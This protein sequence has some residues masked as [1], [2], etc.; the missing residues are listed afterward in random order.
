MNPE[1]SAP[2]PAR[3]TTSYS[4]EGKEE[5]RPA[6][7]AEFELSLLRR[8]RGISGQFKDSA[9]PL[10]V[11]RTAL[12]SGMELLAASEGCVAVLPPDDER[13]QII[14]AVPRESIWDDC[15]L[16]AFIRG[17][18]IQMP[19][20]LALGRLRRRGRMWG[21]L[22]VRS[23][24]AEFGWNAREAIS[25]IAATTS[26]LMEGMD[27][28]RIRDVRARLDFKLI[29]QLRPK[30]L[31]YQVL[32][33]LRTLTDYDHSASLLI[34]DANARHLEVAA[35]QIAWKKTKSQKIGL[36]ITIDDELRHMLC[37]NV[38]LGFDRD[39]NG[40]RPWG[41][42]RGLALAKLLDYN[43]AESGSTS[44]REASVLY[45]PL[46]SRNTLLGLLKIA[47]TRR[48]ILG[49][50]EAN[51]VSHFLPQVTVALQISQRTE[52]LEQQII[53]AHR[54]H[55]MADLARGVSHD[56]NNAL[57]AILPLVQQMQA[58]LGDGRIEPSVFA[59][60]LRAVEESVQVC[61][62]IV[63]GMLSFARGASRNTGQAYVRQSVE[64]ARTILKDG[65]TRRAVDVF[66]D[67]EPDLAPVHGV[68]AD[69]DQLLLNLLSN[70]RDAMPRGGRLSVRAKQRE[71]SVELVVEDTGCGIPPEHMEK[72]KEPFF[73]TKPDGNGLGLAI[74]RSIVWQMRGK[75]DIRSVPGE[76]TRVTV[77]FPLYQPGL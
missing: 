51:L 19:P 6:M 5:A 25:A 15:L 16:S 75:L 63:G 52:S 34:Y 20:N 1:G 61:R 54:K 74:C 39:S 49:P 12:R 30:D 35:E 43:A 29:E 62:R 26:E 38:V 17:E 11:S 69:L 14:F 50:Y 24:S 18:K 21:V 77:V 28:E 53:A 22:A 10:K 40:L 73:S 32:H 65:L 70:S 2:E 58:D 72:I 9:D 37:G 46:V 57:G 47:A 36:R 67:V 3:L 68:Q 55:A 33:G 8:L 71:D 7:T 31:F 56:V 48:G 42:G 44:A 64:C 60:D 59:E 41:E 76:W 66:T 27:E 23:N 4:R 13:A 45:A